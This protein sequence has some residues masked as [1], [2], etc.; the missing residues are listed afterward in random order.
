MA[1]LFSKPIFRI[2]V[3]LRM[4]HQQL[5]YKMLQNDREQA[6]HYLY[7]KY[8]GAL[9]GIISR[10]VGDDNH[11]EEV[12]QDT[13]VKIWKNSEAYNPSL[14]RLFTWMARIARNEAINFVQS[15]SYRNQ[16]RTMEIDSKVICMHSGE[17]LSNG[18]F[19]VKGHVN[20]LD[21]KYKEVLMLSYF[22]G[23]THKEITDK[24]QIPLGTVKTRIKNGIKQ[25]KKLYSDNL[26]KAKTLLFIL[27][28][29]VL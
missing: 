16:S 10:I 18:A 24:L 5:I 17:C 15:K 8:A 3:R 14:G 27:S 21:E 12:L 13:F 22:K 4:P 9:L 11:A 29:I 28:M 26:V 25:L 2:G 23:Y 20:D 6:M 7:D 19:E 1:C